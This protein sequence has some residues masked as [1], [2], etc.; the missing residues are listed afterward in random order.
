MDRPSVGIAL[1]LLAALGVSVTG[2]NRNQSRTS[3]VHAGTAAATTATQKTQPSPPVQVGPIPSSSQATPAAI[4]PAQTATATPAKLV[5]SDRTQTFTVAQQTFR[6]LTHVET[7]A[8][9]TDETVEWW[10]LRTATD[11]V[12]DRG[13][14]P[15]EIE[16]GSFAQTLAI[17]GSDLKTDQG[18]GILIH[19]FELPS[20]PDDSGWVKVFGFKY[21]RDKDGVDESLFG[22]FGPPISVEEGEFL[23]VGADES[24]TTPVSFGG[25]RV[26]TMH[27]VLRFRL[28]TGNFSIVYP[29]LINWITG[30]LQPSFRCPETTSKGRVDRCSYP[31]TVEAHRD[32]KPT[33]V[34]LFP[35]ADDG[36]TPKHI[37]V[38]P[39]SKVEFT[40]ARVPV[41]WTED[42]KSISLGVNG[43]MWLKVRIDGVE[44]WIHGEEDFDAVGL[45][46]SG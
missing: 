22:P 25:A 21:G 10:E 30:Q 17:S 39:E 7:I 23:G 20:A 27:D 19:G 18:G 32:A 37:I 41:T 44:G 5:A 6:L 45:P 28:W 26:T 16:N 38:Q 1:V 3:S 36:F 12:I 9:T 11:R 40:E 46:Q 4:A 8:G 43:D 29:V 13:S 15:V 31:V 42:D 35:E 14:Y 33:F 24:R 2:C 34:R